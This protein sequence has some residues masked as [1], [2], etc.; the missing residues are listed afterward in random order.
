MNRPDNI[1]FER[2]KAIFRAK[3]YVFFDNGRPF[4]L[5]CMGIRSQ[6]VDQQPDLYNDWLGIATRDAQGRSIVEW[7]RATTDPGIAH[8]QDPVFAE[9][10]RGGT[11]IL[12]PGQYRSAYCLGFHGW[13]SY[14][15]QA[16]VQCLPLPVY[17]DR[18]RNSLLDTEQPTITTGLYGINIHA[19]ALHGE[20][21]QVGR[22]S[23]GCQVFASAQDYQRARFWW[24]AQV[25]AGFGPRFT[26]TLLEAVDLQLTA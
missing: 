1:D 2:L 18:N 14:R 11:A 9:A 5:N 7:Y 23:A 20:S 4:N 26:Y 3:G 13:G 12:V 17:R 19:S 15:H 25:Q 16:L 24:N 10:I 6:V 8:L 22:F 21:K